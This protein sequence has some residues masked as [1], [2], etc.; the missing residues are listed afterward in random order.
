MAIKTIAVSEIDPTRSNKHSF[1]GVIPFR[2]LLGEKRITFHTRFVYARQGQSVFSESFVTWYDDCEFNENPKCKNQWRLY[3]PDTL[4][5]S[6][7]K[8]G[9]MLLVARID[10]DELVLIMTPPDSPAGKWIA[11]HYSADPRLETIPAPKPVTPLQIYLPQSF[12]Q[13]K[14]ILTRQVYANDNE[15]QTFYCGCDYSREGKIDPLSCGYVPR[16]AGSKRSQRLEWEHIVPASYIGKG[17]ACWEKG[18]S[19]CTTKNGKSYKGRKCCEKID[20]QF[21]AIEA[22]LNNLVP[23]I[24]ELNADR[25]DFP[26]REIP[27]EER[28]YGACDFEVDTKLREAEPSIPLRGFIGRTWLYMHEAHGVFISDEDAKVYKAWAD[29]FPPQQWEKD[30]QERIRQAVTPAKGN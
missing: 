11:D 29:A 8:A 13:A 5:M 17:R 7:A 23:E 12:T 19:E 18:D 2:N 15:R 28:A 21:R 3:Y 10:D 16:R 25:R 24:G 14:K 26:Y 4:A 9:D 6:K 22:D 1:H 20:A 27:G 30:R